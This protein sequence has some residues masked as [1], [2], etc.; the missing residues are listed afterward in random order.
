[1]IHPPPGTQQNMASIG[2]NDLT[3]PPAESESRMIIF[4]RLF[5][6]ISTSL[7]D[8]G[9][10]GISNSFHLRTRSYARLPSIWM[11]EYFGGS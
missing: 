10:S 9:L 1:M 4:G 7:T 3:Y 5:S 8:I 11:A 6:M 2:A